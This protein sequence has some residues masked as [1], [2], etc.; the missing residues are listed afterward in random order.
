MSEEE[1]IDEACEKIL[2]KYIEA[3]KKLADYDKSE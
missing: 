3:F 2:N 1:I